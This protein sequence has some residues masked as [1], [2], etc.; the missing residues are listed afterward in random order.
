MV[1]LFS[2]QYLAIAVALAG[3]LFF[4][5]PLA[6]LSGTVNSVAL[7]LAA[8]FVGYIVFIVEIAPVTYLCGQ[9][10]RNLWLIM[11]LAVLALAI[12][13]IALTNS[14][15]TAVDAPALAIALSI[16]SVVGVTAIY[17]R[18]TPNA[19]SSIFLSFP[20]SAGRFCAAQGGQSRIIN[21]HWAVDPQ[22]YAVDLV[23]I[24]RFGARTTLAPTELRD[25]LSFGS[26]VLSPAVGTVIEVSDGEPDNAPGTRRAGVFPAGN[27]VLI[28]ADNAEI[29][30][31]HLKCDSVLVSRGQILQ[32][33]TPLGLVGNSGN[34]SE[35][36]L[37]IHAQMAGHG[38]ALRFD[39]RFLVRN[40]VIQ[41]SFPRKG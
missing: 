33:G 30:L 20:A 32:V 38:V 6:E 11:A 2:V 17:L 3:G 28:K 16:L 40:S 34:S 1:N 22:R 37:H 24:G 36:H 13:R 4:A 41:H 21:H 18:R 5:G 29:L 31:A 7:P 15:T 19:G 10:I 8:L 23:K 26:E 12:A 35:P 39:G 27:F 9:L 25:F 14:G